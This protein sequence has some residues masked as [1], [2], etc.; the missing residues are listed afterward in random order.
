ML[1]LLATDIPRWMTQGLVPPVDAGVLV[2]QRADPLGI[3]Q[4]EVGTSE[5]W[6]QKVANLVDLVI[7]VG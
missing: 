1:A 5:C 4:P 7:T 6:C 3:L 2:A